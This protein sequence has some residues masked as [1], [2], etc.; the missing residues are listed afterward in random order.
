MRAG[1][2]RCATPAAAQRAAA[3]V[4]C[5]DGHGRLDV[6]TLQQVAQSLVCGDAAG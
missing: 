2:G 3:Q 6:G 4:V 5:A 1:R